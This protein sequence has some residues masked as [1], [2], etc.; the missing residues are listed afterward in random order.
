M[1]EDGFERNSVG[2][3]H[4]LKVTFT[5]AMLR[6]YL[7]K[8]TWNISKHSLAINQEDMAQ[9]IPPFSLRAIKGVERMNI[10]LTVEEK[11]I[12]VHFGL[13][14]DHLI[15]VQ[16]TI[17][18]LVYAPGDKYYEY[19]LLKQAKQCPERIERTRCLAD[20]VQASL[21]SYWLPKWTDYMMRYLIASNYYSYN[22]RS[23]E[24][25]KTFDKLNFYSSI[26]LS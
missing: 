16:K 5:H 13:L 21:P 9:T 20:F 8:Y 19:L 14:V 23:R 15:G 25:K 22:N 2:M 12:L 7:K 1:T 24:N 26:Q 11:D 3:K 18:P 17:N 10:S 4:I 6:F